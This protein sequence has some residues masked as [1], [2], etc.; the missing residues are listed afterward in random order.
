MKQVPSQALDA[1]AP[2]H[3]GPRGDDMAAML[4]EVGVASLAQ[5]IDEAIPPS[6]RLKAPLT[7]PPAE[8]ESTYLCRLKTIAK[9]N[10]VFRS[11]IGL[12]YH[13]TLTSSVIHR[14]VF[15][16]PGRCRTRRIKRRLRRAALNR[17]QFPDY[18]LG[19]DGHGRGECVATRRGNLCR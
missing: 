9:K 3:I 6:I 11:F 15:E 16:H 19:H 17:P 13:D 12:G 8:S 7:L 5:L 14:M 2:R 18:G 10:K 1:F 4:T